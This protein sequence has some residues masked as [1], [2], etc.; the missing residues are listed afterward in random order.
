MPLRFL[1]PNFHVILIH[2]PLGV[3]VLGVILELGSLV[4]WRR[5]SVR[6]AA[7]WMILLGALLSLPAAT[8]GIYALYDVIKHQGAGS[9][10]RIAFLRRHVWVMSSASL[11]AVFCAVVGLGASNVWREK[12]RLPLLFGVVL[13]WGM[14]VYGAWFG[15]ETIYQ[16]GTSVAIIK[17]E[18]SSE[19]E[20]AKA[21]DAQPVLITPKLVADPANPKKRYA[22]IVKYYM[23]GELQMHMIVAGGALAVAFGALGLSIRRMTT[24]RA[25]EAA[26]MAAI[27]G[28]PS[29]V[30]APPRRVTDDVTV[31]RTLNPDALVDPDES[32]V[33]VAR[34]WLL[35]ALVL[36]ATSVLGYW[37]MSDK[38]FFTSEGLKEDFWKL[39]QWDEYKR[40]FA[41]LVLGGA[42]VVVALFFTLTALWLPRRPVPVIFFGTLLVAI[43]AGQ[44][45]LGVLLT[46][47]DPK[48]GSEASQLFHFNAVE[49]GNP[50]PHGV[51]RMP[52]QKTA[53]QPGQ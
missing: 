1:N 35:A 51:E 33:P 47:D 29:L 32:R 14:M 21:A 39:V 30:S 48:D 4:L 36:I 20:A 34:F 9:T 24:L 27:E 43:A 10:Q 7:R 5:S 19:D 45:W 8:S 11:L 38:H 46:F 25:A 40:H 23:A 37:V 31:M 28:D 3:F 12:L 18:S 16:Q 22:G 6:T 44:I 53:T 50:E 41:H 42:L 13:A 17:Y 26:D 52:E 15:G 2:Y 49:K